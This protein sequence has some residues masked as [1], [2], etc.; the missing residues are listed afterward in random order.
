MTKEHKAAISRALKGRVVSEETRK[1]IS[2]AQ[3]KRIKYRCDYCGGWAESKPSHFKLKKRHFCSR[4]CYSLYRKE[5]LPKEEHNAYKNG[6]LPEEEKKKR[7]YAR[8]WPNHAIRDGR[9][10]RESC[11]ICGEKA[12]AH[13]PDYEQPRLVRWLCKEH[14]WQVHGKE[15]HVA[16]A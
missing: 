10:E 8:A 4:K 9:L 16:E 6:G 3:R 5:F 7:I 14:H 15:L 1:K 2:L 13:H 12:E 11:E